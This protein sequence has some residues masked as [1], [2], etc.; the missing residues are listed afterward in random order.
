MRRTLLCLLLFA[1]CG[2]V[3]ALEVFPPAPD[4]QTYLKISTKTPFCSVARTDVA[5]ESLRITVNVIPNASACPV[6]ALFPL[7]ANVGVVPP[8]VYDVIVRTLDGTE[9]DHSTAI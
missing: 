6:A 4:S 3:F 2:S 7:Q 5:V 1:C 9:L 8:G